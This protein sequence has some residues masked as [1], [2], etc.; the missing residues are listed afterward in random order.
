MASPFDFLNSVNYTKDWIFDGEQSESDYVPF[1][2]NRTLSYTP[3]SV[4]WANEVNRSEIPK[5]W[6]YAFLFYA[7]PKRKRYAK[8]EKRPGL[9]EDVAVLME[10]FSYSAT[11]AEVALNVLNEDQLAAIRLELRQH[12]SGK[13]V[14]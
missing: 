7:L 3:D 14:G 9:A 4:M 12:V 11:K 13:R 6:Q 8:W 1:V 2:V 5:E 10:A